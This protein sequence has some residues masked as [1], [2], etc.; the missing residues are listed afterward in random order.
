M[1]YRVNWD[2][3]VKQS[4][5]GIVEADSEEEALKLLKA[6]LQEEDEFVDEDGIDTS[7]HM[8][9]GPEEY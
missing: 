2:Y 7:G 1:R 5:T 3:F 6:G 8:V 9:E 4:W